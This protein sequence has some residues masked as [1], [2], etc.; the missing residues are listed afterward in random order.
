[1]RQLK[2]ELL[3]DNN[4]TIKLQY[5]EFE[6]KFF[7]DTK[8]KDNRIIYSLISLTNLVLMTNFMDSY[9]ADGNKLWN[10]IM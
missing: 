1:M 4:E 5:P 2:S 10:L 7:N 6:S 8:Y 9:L 3:F